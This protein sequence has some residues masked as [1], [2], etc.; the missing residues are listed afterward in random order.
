MP[1][2]TILNQSEIAAAI[3]RM[4]N[5]LTE[6]HL[7]DGQ[8]ALV[9]I[10]RGGEVLAQRLLDAL[11]ER[12][13]ERPQYGAV[14]ISLYRDD[15]FGPSDWPRL[16]PTHIDFPLSEYTVILVDDVL[17]TGRTVRAAIDAILDYGRPKAVRLAVLVDRGLRELPIYGDVV[18]HRIITQASDNVEV[19]LAAADDSRGDDNSDDNSGDET[20]SD[21]SD[22][23]TL[24]RT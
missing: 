7:I 9:A 5:E 22:R 4:A 18:G 10:R 15:G 6:S 17:Y 12:L 20:R 23:V 2:S 11:E 16:G 21:R 3:E 19:F 14:D 8:V 13:G 1:Q 24:E